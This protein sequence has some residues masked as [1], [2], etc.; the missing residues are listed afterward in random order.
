MHWLIEF[1]WYIGALLTIACLLIHFIVVVPALRVNGSGY[2]TGWNNINHL[3]ELNKYK[4]ICMR[5]G[6][7]LFWYETEIKIFKLLILWVI[8]WIALLILTD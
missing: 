2:L 5:D 3:A 7:S 4:Q 1:Y 6:T 8:G